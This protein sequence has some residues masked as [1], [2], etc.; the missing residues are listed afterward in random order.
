MNDITV[1][2]ALYIRIQVLMTNIR[3]VKNGLRVIY[4]NIDVLTKTKKSE[5]EAIVKLKDPDI[6][7]LTEIFPKNSMFGNDSEF[8]QM[9]GYDTFI[10]DLNKGM[11]I[12]IYVKKCLNGMEKEFETEYS[13]AV[14]CEITLK[15]KD[16]LTSWLQIS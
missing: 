4:T 6:I 3:T 9:R 7:A 5:L 12:V 2:L 16:K 14:W 10:S 1:V 11:G 13:E 8:F 15:R